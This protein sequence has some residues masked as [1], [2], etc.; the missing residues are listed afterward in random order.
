MKLSQPHLNT[1]VVGE[2]LIN[3]DTKAVLRDLH[4]ERNI[5][6]DKDQKISDIA[7]GFSLDETG[8]V[9]HTSGSRFKGHIIPLS[10][11]T[12]IGAA[13]ARVKMNESVAKATHNVY[14][15]LLSD[16][17]EFMSDN[18]ELGAAQHILD[19][20]GENNVVDQLIVVTRWYGGHMGP[21]RF[22]YYRDIAL[23]AACMA[24]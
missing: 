10:D 21:E 3:S 17:R 24:K 9:N 11:P 12:L 23:Q 19:V 13:L 22:T 16:G 5:C 7:L 4:K 8:C 2:R 1:Y 20:L 18:G 6:A 15:L 14:G